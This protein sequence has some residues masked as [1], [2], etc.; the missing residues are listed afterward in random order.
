MRN[1]ATKKSRACFAR[2]QY[3][4]WLQRYEPVKLGEVYEQNI[5]KTNWA[6]KILQE[7]FYI[8]EKS[9]SLNKL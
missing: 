8:L 1:I 2:S 7:D 9:Y 3:R 6:Y 4:Y 5:P